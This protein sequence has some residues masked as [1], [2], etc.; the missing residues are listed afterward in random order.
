MPDLYDLMDNQVLGRG[1]APVVD[2][3]YKDPFFTR[4]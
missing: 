2:A 1:L 3:L 4:L